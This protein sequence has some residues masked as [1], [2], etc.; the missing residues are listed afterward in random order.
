MTIQPS[1]KF[2]N[3]LVLE[4][5]IPRST[6]KGTRERRMSDRRLVGWSPARRRARSGRLGMLLYLLNTGPYIIT[7]SSPAW[8][9]IQQEL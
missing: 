3:Q 2:N 8:S 6:E 5:T 9:A 7:I 4:G 1:L